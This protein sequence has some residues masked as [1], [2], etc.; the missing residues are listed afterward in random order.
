MTLRP[1][2]VLK[3]STIFEKLRAIFKVYIYEKKNG[4][5]I[6]VTLKSR[7]LSNFQFDSDITNTHKIRIQVLQ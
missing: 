7:L 1:S 5:E 6:I 2:W 4:N 3:S